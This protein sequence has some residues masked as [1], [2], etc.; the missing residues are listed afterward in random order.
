MYLPHFNQKTTGSIIAR[1]RDGDDAT[2]AEVIADPIR[3]VPNPDVSEAVW[4]AFEEFPTWTRP[5]KTARS[6]TSRL[7]SASTVLSKYG[8]L[9]DAV[10][11]AEK[12]IV[13]TM[14]GHFEA[15][16]KW[17]EDKVGQFEEV[18]YIT[19]AVDW[20][21]GVETHSQ[22]ASLAIASRNI[23][24]LFKQSKAR[25]PDASA[26]W[27][28]QHLVKEGIYEEPAE[29]KLYVAALAQ[30]ADTNTVIEAAANALLQAWKQQHLSELAHKGGQAQQDFLSVF[31]E[32]KV[33]EQVTTSA[34]KPTS[35]KLVESSW[36]KHLL[37][38]APGQAVE[39][40]LF[41]YKPAS[42]WE[43]T[44]LSTELGRDG[45]VAW[46]RNPPGGPTA[47]AVPYGE[48]D[49]QRML[50]PDFVIFTRRDDESIGVSIVDPHQPNQGDTLA[51]WFA[52]G[53]YAKA[54]ADRL[55]RV[56]AVIDDK[57]VDGLLFLDLK[58]PTARASLAKQLTGSGDIEPRVRKAFAEAGGRYT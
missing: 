40:G 13:E 49:S 41:P 35:V 25:M 45:T 29:A 27:L 22:E 19:H 12:R 53:E 33:S 37:G 3:V 38:A 15:H 54:N 16:R 9:D 57:D 21:S 43:A 36:P 39:E 42:S 58:D 11:I 14:L 18:D 32:S 50:Y 23:D 8:V 2:A 47:I 56:W 48:Q 46:F 28:W 1:L 10:R 51:K 17:V 5:V 52:L 4:E 30:Q 34:P 7:V 31:V 26:S 44:A 24:D 55:D 20:L 6:T